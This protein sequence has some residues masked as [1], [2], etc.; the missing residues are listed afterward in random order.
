MDNKLM[1]SPNTIKECWFIQ[2]NQDLMEVPKVCKSMKERVYK[3]VSINK[4]FNLVNLTSLISSNTK[5]G[6]K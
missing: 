4:I 2:L 5:N 1:Y 3:T 6:A